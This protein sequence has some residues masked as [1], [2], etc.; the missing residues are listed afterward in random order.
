[1]KV[2]GPHFVHSNRNS[3]RFTCGIYFTYSGAYCAKYSFVH[4]Y[5]CVVKF[6]LWR[7]HTPSSLSCCGGK[8]GKKV[9]SCAENNCVRNGSF[10]RVHAI[11]LQNP[12]K[13]NPWKAWRRRVAEVFQASKRSF[14]DVL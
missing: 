11:L 5:Y 2:L 8:I 7:P 12:P 4:C 3:S 13:F 6:S 9:S 10:A 14:S 1:M